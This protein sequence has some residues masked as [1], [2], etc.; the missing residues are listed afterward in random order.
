MNN[1]LTEFNNTLDEF[2]TK[3]INQ[4]PDEYKLKTY[5]NTFKITKMYDKS[6]PIKIF[7]GGCLKFTDQIKNRD[8][9]FFIQ[10]KEFVTKLKNCT[11]FSDDIGLVKYWEDLSEISK[12][13][14]WDYVQTLYIIGE[15]YIK[16]DTSI[17]N[18][19]NNI[20]NNLSHDEFENINKN[21]KITDSLISKIV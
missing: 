9:E 16:K 21:N 15:M 20:Y 7:M 1:V 10:T 14:I 6:L 3:L 4:F 18:N 17:I 2:I 19:I 11:S 5:Y 13:S 8:S 12:K